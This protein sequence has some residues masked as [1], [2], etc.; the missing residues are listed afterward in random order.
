MNTKTVRRN[1]E[2]LAVLAVFDSEPFQYELI[3]QEAR[4][5]LSILDDDLAKWHSC[6]RLSWFHQR[7]ILIFRY[8]NQLEKNSKNQ[9]ILN[10][11]KALYQE[12]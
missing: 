2:I 12:F 10:I 3:R 6:R 1:L 11:A 8:S 4:N 7:L 9:E 5:A